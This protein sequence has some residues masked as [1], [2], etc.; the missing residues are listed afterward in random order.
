MKIRGMIVPESEK[1]IA[2]LFRDPAFLHY[3]IRED[4]SD[5]EKFLSSVRSEANEK[6]A[7]IVIMT[8]RWKLIFWKILS[9]LP[10]DK[11]VLE[12][13]ARKSGLD[14]ENGG[15]VIRNGNEVFIF[16]VNINVRTIKKSEK[17]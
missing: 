13:S 11:D 3:V 1:E 15:P 2:N 7:D 6:D 8:I 4:E 14:I 5:A 16:P 10:K 17:K 9:I 12:S